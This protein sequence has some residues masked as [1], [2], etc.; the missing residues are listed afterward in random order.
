LSPEP[1]QGKFFMIQRVFWALLSGLIF[2]V[3]LVVGGMT[4]TAK[5]LGFL[6]IGGI[7]N[8][9]SSTAERGLWDP[10]L[11][12]VMGGALLVSVVAFAVT[13]RKNKPWADIQFHLPTRN[14]IDRPLLLGGALFGIGWGLAGYCPGPAFASLLSGS[15]DVMIFMIAMG[16]GM[17]AAK[18]VTA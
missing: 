18:R 16:A 9:V 3:G 13:P 17:W 10:S 8:G 6:D 14:D 2:G 5:V 4:Q 15:T 11:A 12:F 7:A 1:V